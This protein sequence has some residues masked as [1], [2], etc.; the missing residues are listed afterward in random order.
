MAEK[1]NLD[2]KSSRIAKLEKKLPL[3]RFIPAAF[4][5][6]LLCVITLSI[7]SYQNIEEYKKD[8]KRINHSQEIMRQNADINT[9]AYR[10]TLFR[11]VYQNTGDNKYR[12]N[13]YDS[14]QKLNE[15]IENLKKLTIDNSIQQ[16]SIY[17]L[18]SLIKKRFAVLDST[19]D[20]YYK[21]KKIPDTEADIT[22]KI[23]IDL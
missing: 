12:V 23:R 14:K 15:E 11:K 16:N 2:K 13:Y 18:D 3:E 22:D 21:E 10:L 9:L 5:V 7:I 8:V 20:L 19:V 1:S 4:M 6:F 17:G